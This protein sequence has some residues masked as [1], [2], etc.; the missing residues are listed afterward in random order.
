MNL[1][2]VPKIDDADLRKKADEIRDRFW[3]GSLPIDVDNLCEAY[4]LFLD[5]YPNLRSAIDA[6]S[7]LLGNLSEIIYDASASS[8]RAT[9]SLAHELGHFQLHPEFIRRTRSAPGSSTPNR[10]EALERW[11][12][13]LASMEPSYGRVEYQAYEFAGR[14]LVPMERLMEELEKYRDLI[15]QG[16]A[17]LAYPSS[18]DF[19]PYV[20]PKIAPVFGVSAAVIEKRIEKEGIN[21]M[22]V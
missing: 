12:N 13:Y 16:A 5:P 20:A 15:R 3:D 18:R 10:D 2:E 7:F 22:R 6:E 4:G 17:R 21:L 11:K 8:V 1:D 9:F 14:L 19:I